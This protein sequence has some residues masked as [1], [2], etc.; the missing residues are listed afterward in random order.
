MS[1]DQPFR[2][3][4]PFNPLDK[5]AL[6]RNVTS[7]LLQQIM[8]PLP[9][10]PFWGVGVYAIYYTGHVPLYPQVNLSET[11]IYVGKAIPK[12]GRKGGLSDGRQETSLFDRLREHANS[13]SQAQN[14]ALPDFSCRFLAVD[15]AWIP[16]AESLLIEEFRPLWNVLIEGFGIHNP[17]GGRS[18]QKRSI[19]GSLHPGRPWADDLAPNPRVDQ[20]IAEL[21]G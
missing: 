8:E 11:P 9:P 21:R 14:L 18:G 19:W 12:G 5:L 20:V 13:I 15:D 1:P 2:V 10:S 7:H 17:G 4:P 3:I 16:L 6:G